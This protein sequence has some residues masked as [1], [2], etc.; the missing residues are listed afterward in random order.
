MQTLVLLKGLR[1][2]G[3]N[4][5]FDTKGMEVVAEEVKKGLAG[6]VVVA[7]PRYAD[8]VETIAGAAKEGRAP[9]SLYTMRTSLEE[10]LRH[11][12]ERGLGARFVAT[13]SSAARA[14]VE[15]FV[16]RLFIYPWRF[17][18][19]A[20][21]EP[22]IVYP[23]FKMGNRLVSA[24]PMMLDRD[25]AVAAAIKA[26]SENDALRGL[27]IDRVYRELFNRFVEQHVEIA[28]R[29]LEIRSTDLVKEMLPQGA[30]YEELLERSYALER[31]GRSL[32]SRLLEEECE[33]PIPQSLDRVVSWARGVLETL[34]QVE[35]EPTITEPVKAIARELENLFRALLSDAKAGVLSPAT[36]AALKRVDE[37]F[38]SLLGTG[39]LWGPVTSW[40][41]AVNS[42]TAAYHRFLEAVQ[43]LAGSRALI[44][45]R[46][47]WAKRWA[48]AF[49]STLNEMLASD[50]FV[51]DEDLEPIAI[52]VTDKEVVCRLGSA[53]GHAAHVDIERGVLE[54]YDTDDDVK[55]AMLSILRRLVPVRRAVDE[56]EKLVVW[57]DPTPENIEGVVAALPLA[58]SMD[59]RLQ[60]LEAEVE[61][62]FNTMLAQVTRL[63]ER[64][65]SEK[66]LEEA[67][68]V[69]GVERRVIEGLAEA[70]RR[71]L[72]SAT[73]EEFHRWLTSYRGSSKPVAL[74]RSFFEKLQEKLGQAETA[75]ATIHR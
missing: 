7:P 69:F 67:A 17:V 62:E 10:F 60:E 53:E 38:R 21:R 5:D 47:P 63:L 71:A 25:A 12:F 20:S 15:G 36:T 40:S 23:G 16:R 8:R 55:K 35:E 75:K 57:F 6:L 65:E 27:I 24:L 1:W 51:A 4:P 54:Y 28:G 26:M 9:V 43:R 74:L 29:A 30:V 14:I 70:I 34:R 48:E 58:I 41:S 39:V 59:Y 22:F 31:D 44:L 50:L 3:L 68:R 46:N 45:T 56:G 49:L 64:G 33:S 72:A 13:P 19:D 18:V 2:R 66:A 61:R 73:P 11:V 37:E 42:A 32:A 52:T